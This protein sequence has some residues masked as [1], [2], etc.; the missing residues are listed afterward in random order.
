MRFLNFTL[1]KLCLGFIGGIYLGFFI[2]LQFK[3]FAFFGL[4]LV[5]LLVIFRWIWHQKLLF[6]WSSVVLFALLGSLTTYIHLPQNKPHHLTHLDFKSQDSFAIQADVSEVLRENA[7]NHKYILDNLKIE[8]QFYEGKILLNVSKDSIAKV[9]NLGDKIIMSSSLQPFYN[10]KN[11]QTFDYAAFMQNRDVFAVVYEDKF[12]ISTQSYFSLATYAGQWRLKIISALRDAGFRDKHLELIQALILGQKQAINR[13]TYNEFA[14][15]GVVHILAVSGLHVGIVFLILNFLLSP[16]L[17]FKHGRPL[18]VLLTILSLWGFAALAGFSP[19]VMRAVTMFSFLAFGQMFRRKTNSINMLCLSAV[20]LLIY[21]PQLLFEV[22]FQLSYAA[23]FAIVMLYPVFSKLY[24]PRYKIPKL[25]WDTAY[26]SLAAQIGVLPFQL[27]YF[28]QFPGL[29]LLGN[30]VIIPFLG[31]LIGGGLT[32]IL[33]ALVGALI[34]PLVEVYVFLLDL[35]VYYVNWLSQFKSFVIEN[36]FFTKPMFVTILVLVLSFM[37]MMREFKKAYVTV[38]LVSLLAFTVVSVSE[39][40]KIDKHSE[41][42]VFHQNRQSLIGIK[43]GRQL[44]IF[45]D[46]TDN[47]SD[48]YLLNN[49]QL[50]NRIDIT[51]I[52]PLKNSFKFSKLRL[53]VIDSSGVYLKET[54]SDVLILSQSPDIHLEKLIKTIKPKKIIADGNN[55]KSYVERWEYTAKKHDIA[56]HST[57]KSGSFSLNSP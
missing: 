26:V 38:F 13:E 6:L 20:V 31:V 41:L 3:T 2:D 55:Y 39:V 44:Q 42:I 50:I 10:A 16:V 11:P 19:S 18:K 57:Y 48:T 24:Q 35:L 5:T 37:L 23:V 1:I 40:S 27:F 43:Q 49:Y 53:T 9:L 14:D 28:H 46:K 54:K 36:I 33:L 25:F 22:G 32:C 34:S 56:F 47:L 8:N 15:V 52:K 7:Y 45:S 29:F 12:E 30:L 51:E 4:S 17:R 21:K